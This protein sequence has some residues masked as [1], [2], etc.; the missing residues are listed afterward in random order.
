MH[1]LLQFHYNLGMLLYS[2]SKG[3]DR[4]GAVFQVADQ[5][6]HGISLIQPEMRVEFVGLN[7]S[8]GSRA[9][10]RCYKTAYSYLKNAFALLPRN[11]WSSHYELSLRVFLLYA[12]SAYSC[13]KVKKAY[14]ALKT[15]LQ[16]GRCA[17]DKLDAY[18]LHVTVSLT[19]VC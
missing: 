14:K 13:G 10:S 19:H 3:Q 18:L 2:A 6:N 1:I 8:A 5:I 15:I 12:K 11:S 7:F 17:N 9:I 4:S 16:K